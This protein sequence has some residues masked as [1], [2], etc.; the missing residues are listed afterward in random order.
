LI[1]AKD[2]DAPRYRPELI[3]FDER[4][5]VAKE[6]IDACLLDWAQS[7]D[8]KIKALIMSAFQVDKR[9]RINT[10]RI[11]G[12]RKLEIDNERWHQTMAAIGEAVSVRDTAVYFRFNQQSG[13]W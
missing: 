10:A 8:P 11:L 6:L 7:S 12:L 9:G 4:L 5:Q 3:N 1:S 13:G 2:E